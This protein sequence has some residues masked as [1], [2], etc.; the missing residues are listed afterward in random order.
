MSNIERPEILIAGIGNIFLGDDAFGVEVVK[1]LLT[2]S[3]PKEVLVV[4]YGIRSFDLA[5]ALMDG[6]RATIFVDATMRGGV[7]GTIYVI[8]PEIDEWTQLADQAEIPDGH[9][10]NPVKVLTLVKNMGGIFGRLLLVGCE[11]QTLELPEGFMGLSEPVAAAVDEAILVI[12][13]LI[14]KILAE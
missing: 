8:E 10:M 9:S 11:P 2:R 7:P 12:E 13:S 3:L 5:Y 6:Y 1:R 14:N 4:D